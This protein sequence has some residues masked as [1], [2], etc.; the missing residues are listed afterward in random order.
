MAATGTEAAMF[1][2]QIQP[3]LSPTPVLHRRPNPPLHLRHHHV[4]A[5]D[6]MQRWTLARPIGSTSPPKEEEEWGSV[7]LALNAV[8]REGCYGFFGGSWSRTRVARACNP[9]SCFCIGSISPN[10]HQVD[11]CFL[12]GPCGSCSHHLCIDNTSSFRLF[13]CFFM[14]FC[15]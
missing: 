11:L 12:D 9:G 5:P 14:L 1:L 7:V 6:R 13:F 3:R 15:S 2:S 10:W 4:A 8:R